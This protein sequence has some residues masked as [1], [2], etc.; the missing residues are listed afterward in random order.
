MKNTYRIIGKTVIMDLRRE[1]GGTLKCRF[2]VA[3]L[4]KLKAL[5]VAWVAI[6]DYSVKSEEKYYV[7]RNAEGTTLL[8][9]R[10]LMGE[11]ADGLVVDHID[12]NPLNN[13]R[14][15]LRLLTHSQNAL[16]R[17]GAE[18]RSK[19]GILGVSWIECKKRFRG[20]VKYKGKAV[21]ERL[22]K[23]DELERAEMEV[24]EIRE[25]LINGTHPIQNQVK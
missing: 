7:G 2:D 6:Q 5:D 25:M 18:L 15:N 9:H 22:Y 19:S 11:V 17:K 12:G 10:Y 1:S 21:F 4:P 23:E 8:L 13:K 24:R 20:R 14:S 16:N 3:D